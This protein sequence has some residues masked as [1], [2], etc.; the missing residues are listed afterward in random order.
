MLARRPSLALLLAALPLVTLP[1][2]APAPAR[3]CT[4]LPPGVSG[5]IPTDGGKYP[6]NAAILLMGNGIDLT[7]ATV[8]VDGQ[9]AALKDAT[10]LLAPGIGSVGALVVPPP[11]AGQMV[12]VSGTFCSAGEMCPVTTIHYQAIAADTTAPVGGDLVGFNV[13]DYTDFKS[14]GG[15]CQSDSD[16]AWF[17]EGKTQVPDPAGSPEMYTFEALPDA[18]STTPVFTQ[19]GFIP[20]SGQPN[21]T[22][23]GLASQLMGKS[24]P[25][26]LCFRMRSFD[27]AGNTPAT[28]METLCKPCYYRADSSP[29]MGF[30]PPAEPMWKVA[31]IYPGGTCDSSM[32]GVG[33][34]YPDGGVSHGEGGSGT[35]SGGAGG[36]GAQPGQVV[37]GCGCRVEG[38]DGEGAAGFGAVVFLALSAIARRRLNRA[39]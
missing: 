28:S 17:V 33:G 34:N 22:L 23:R 13:L 29:L 6:G 24:L 16:F 2:L 39:V 27:A 9:P 10:A 35:G 15:D 30:G 11:M 19:S 8:T 3:A 5:S 36:N 4:P 7:A 14:S 31:D 21:A 20:D 12:V 18:Q 25:E 37:G 26:A 1:L 38:S 32:S